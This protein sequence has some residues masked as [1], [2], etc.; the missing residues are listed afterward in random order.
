MRHGA[1]PKVSWMYRSGRVSLL[2]VADATPEEHSIRFIDEHAEP[3]DFNIKTDVVGVSFSTPLAPRA[4]EIGDEFRRRGVPVIFG[5]YHATFL[6]DE[7]LKHCDSVC[8]GEAEPVWPR[9]LHDLEH[10]KLGRSYHSVARMDLLRWRP[11]RKAQWDS[12]SHEILNVVMAGRGCPRACDFCS[13]TEFFG[14][15]YRHRPVGEIVKEIEELGNRFVLLGDDNI[16][17]DRVFTAEL[18]R[19]ME[20]LKIHWMGQG[21]LTI[22]DDPELVTLAARSGCRGIFIGLDSL[23]RENLESS[24]KGFCDV[25]RYA[26]CVSRLTDAGIAVLAGFVFGFDNDDYRV[27]DRTVKFIRETSLI[28]TQIAI[29]TPFPGTRLYDRLA[30]EQRIFDRDW[31]H[32]DCRHVVFNPKRMTAAELQDGTDWV[33]R[34]TYSLTSLGLKAYELLPVLG[35]MGLFRYALPMDFACRQDIRNHN[36]PKGFRRVSRLASPSVFS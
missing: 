5:G 27:F 13:V 26:E 10:W 4:Y 29:L 35:P 2:A 17:A 20:P 28:A 24:G 19:A 11:L 14:N 18:F 32:Y 23:T 1:R 21:T 34:E 22:A 15:T 25:S 30:R 6:P 16:V 8:I 33:I 3:I 31:A 9:M 7:A 12:D 36:N